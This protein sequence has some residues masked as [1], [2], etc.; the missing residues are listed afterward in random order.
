[1]LTKPNYLV[2]H[3]TEQLFSMFYSIPA[4]LL[5]PRDQKT[6]HSHT[7][8]SIQLYVYTHY[9]ILVPQRMAYLVKGNQGAQIDK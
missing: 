2:L 6:W 7:I 5:H 1:M 3:S 9:K 8:F 4:S